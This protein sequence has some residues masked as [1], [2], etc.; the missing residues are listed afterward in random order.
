LGGVRALLWGPDEADDVFGAADLG[1]VRRV[2]DLGCGRGFWGRV[3]LDRFP[4]ARVDGF[5]LDD[6]A[7]T[8]GRAAAADV[9]GRLTFTVAD[10]EALDVRD[11]AY[12]LVTTHAVLVHQSRPERTLEEARRILRP[13]GRILLVEPDVRAAFCA[14]DP[15]PP[16]A[17]DPWPLILA[18]AAATGARWD[19]GGD[20]ASLLG[21]L[22][23]VAVRRHP[24]RFRTSPLLGGHLLTRDEADEAAH[25]ELLEGLHRAGGGSDDAW[26]TY[27]SGLAEGRRERTRRLRDGSFAVDAWGGLHVAVGRV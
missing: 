14:L 12:D 16:A 22:R 2:A 19:L 11:G 3:L 17:V 26:G 27:A 13:G 21:R 10:I 6:G 7:V 15:L 1:S 25:V 8:A 9:R 20:M 18:G 23:E 4:R 24:G 5:D